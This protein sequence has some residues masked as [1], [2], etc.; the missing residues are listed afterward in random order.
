MV[1]TIFPDEMKALESEYMSRHQIPSLLLMELAAQGIVRAMLRHAAQDAGC[2]FLCGPG[3]NG[4]DG[5]AAARIWH[6]QGGRALLVELT[7]APST[8]DARI[9]RNLCMERGIPAI[10]ADAFP[11]S[12]PWLPALAVDAVYGTGFHGCLN[13]QAARL[14]D[15]I[16]SSGIPAIAVDIPSGLNGMDGSASAHTLRAVETVT[17]H[18]PKTGLYLAQGPA[19]TGNVTVH[20][21]LI[22]KETG[23]SGLACM[24]PADLSVVLSRR[25]P[26]SHKGSFGRIVLY[27][28][29]PGM[30][31]AAAMAARACVK[32]GAGLVTLV[33]SEILLP[34]L[35]TLVPAAMCIPL[36][37]SGSAWE[38]ESLQ[39]AETAFQSADVIITGCGLG[40]DPIHLAV[41]EKLRHISCPV[42]WDADALNLMARHPEW[43]P[44]KTED[45]I[46]PHPG[47]AARLLGT[48][49]GWITGNS[50]QALERLQAV[51]G[52]SVLLKGARSLMQSGASAA[53][54]V[55]TSPALARGGSGDML[56]GILAACLA[57][58]LPALQAMQTACLIHGLAAVR[59]AA[60]YGEDCATPEDI[61]SCIRLDATGLPS[62]I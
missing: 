19:Y 62:G 57:R 6:D 59:A 49:T 1:Y 27:C 26:L 61:L 15:W 41:L 48:D 17:F 21:I 35:Q 45:F 22:P 51:T 42:I 29:H 14:F 43:L 8:P 28:G 25:S 50:L 47:E 9:N 46:T 39:A 58:R 7:D 2:I 53:V 4:G 24:E 5:Y 40:Q 56:C 52:C 16:H 54:N 12:L 11:D 33:C 44:L 20:P 18:R 10:A 23:C 32:S 31:G 37:S 55:Y 60:Q 38:T 3:N 30:A 13:E 36:R 34:V